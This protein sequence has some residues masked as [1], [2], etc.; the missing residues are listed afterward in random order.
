MDKLKQLYD[1][2]YASGD[3]TKSFED[4]KTQFSTLE[5]ISNL[6]NGLVESGDYTKSIGEFNVQF[7]AH[8]KKKDKTQISP[9]V[10][11]D[12]TSVSPSGKVDKKTDESFDSISQFV[13]PEEPLSYNVPEAEPVVKLSKDE[14][15]ANISNG[16]GS[17]DLND[18]I[19]N[20]QGERI[21]FFD[22]Y[23]K[24]EDEL[25]KLKLE[26]IRIDNLPKYN[27]GITSKS[28]LY[29]D[30]ITAN[31][32]NIENASK[33]WTEYVQQK[34][35]ANGGNVNFLSKV[36]LAQS[37]VN[38]DYIKTDAFI[39]NGE[40]TSYNDM[41]SKLMSGDFMDD[42]KS[43][44]INISINGD[45]NSVKNGIT[46]K[47]N[48]DELIKLFN[49]QKNSV[50]K[51][52]GLVDIFAGAILSTIGGRLKA[53]EFLTNI[54]ISGLTGAKVSDVKNFRDA[55]PSIGGIST[56]L[57]PAINAI[58]KGV[59]FLDNRQFKEDKSLINAIDDGDFLHVGMLVAEKTVGM[60]P[61]VIEGALTGGAAPYL[62]ALGAVG[63]K[64]EALVDENEMAIIRKENGLNLSKDEWNA[65]N[66]SNSQMILNAGF[67]G[68]L[69]G[70]LFGKWAE[71][72]HI[73][74][75]FM[76]FNPKKV[77]D[78][79]KSFSDGILNG[80]KSLG[81][82]FSNQGKGFVANVLNQEKLLLGLTGGNY[83]VDAATGI[84]KTKTIG[85]DLAERAVEGV[86]LAIP[87][88]GLEIKNE[89]KQIKTIRDHTTKLLLLDKLDRMMYDDVA[90]MS[91]FAEME[92]S[93][94][95]QDLARDLIK[96]NYAEM[97]I[98][99][100]K[101]KEH[102]ALMSSKEK[103]K[104]IQDHQDIVDLG[105][106]LE[107][108]GEGSKEGKVLSKLID[109]KVKEFE[110]NREKLIEKYQPEVDIIESEK[111]GLTPNT[112]DSR[113]T[114]ET[115]SSETME[116][117]MIST[118]PDGQPANT[119]KEGDV[120]RITVNKLGTDGY[121]R[122]N[123]QMTQSF[124]T[125]E[126]ARNYANKFISKDTKKEVKKGAITPE[127]SINYSNLTED[128][129]GNFVF[130][131]RT[132]T[133]I[134]S[135]DPKKSGSNK[136]APTSKEEVV[137]NNK[138][139]G[140]SF[141][142]TSSKSGESTVTGKNTYEVKIPKD[143]VY[144][145]DA[146][147]LNLKD[148]AKELH[149][150]EFPN[151]AFDSNTKLAYITKLAGEKGFD[152][153]VAK[154]N[155]ETRAQS[156]KVIK[157]TDVQVSGTKKVFKDNH[158]PNTEKGFETVESVSKD[159]ELEKVYSKII[160][161]IS[162]DAKNPLY[163]LKDQSFYGFKDDFS[164]FKTQESITKVIEESKLPKKLKDEYKK[165]L[166]TVDVKGY[167]KQTGK[168][169]AD[170]FTGKAKEASSKV[171]YKPVLNVDQ[172]TKVAKSFLKFTDGG[173]FTGHISKMIAGFAEKQLKVAE[174]IVSGKFK[175]F[176]DLGSSE[177]GL[178]KTVGE[179]SP[180]MKVVGIDPNPTMRKNFNKTPKVKN[181]DYRLE[182]LGASW[183]EADG[184]VIKEFKPKEKFDVINED[185]TF[186]F[187]NGDRKTQIK[188]VKEILTEDGLFITSEKMHTANSKKNEAKKYDHQKKYFNK[189]QL[190]ED[191]QTIISGMDKDMI[192]DVEYFKILSDNFKY[193]KEF[194]NAGDFKG[195]IAS[196][197]LSKVERFLKDVG[198][199]DSEFTDRESLTRDIKK[200][201][202]VEKKTNLDLNN[203]F[204]ELGF[205][206]SNKE[207]HFGK[208]ELQKD[209][210]YLKDKDRMLEISDILSNNEKLDA[211][212]EKVKSEDEILKEKLNKEVE[213]LKKDAKTVLDGIKIGKM[214][215]DNIKKRAI[216]IA[217]KFIAREDLQKMTGIEFK[218]ILTKIERAKTE[219]TIQNLVKKI[220][221]QIHLTEYRVNEAKVNKLLKAKF[222]KIESGRL[223]ANTATEEVA[224]MM[225]TIKVNIDTKG[226]KKENLYSD[227][228]A[229][230]LEKIDALNKK[231]QLTIKE[232]LDLEALSISNDILN[233]KLLGND[234][235]E[236]KANFLRDSFNRLKELRDAD[237]VKL[238]EIVDAQKKLDKEFIE[239]GIED[240]D[241]TGKRES[242]KNKIKNSEDL[243]KQANQAKHILTRTAFNLL[244]GNASGTLESII[245]IISR[246]GGDT[247]G[248]S[249]LGRMKAGLVHDIMQRGKYIDV[250]AKRIS[251]MTKSIFGRSDRFSRAISVDPKSI[252]GLGNRIDITIR[253]KGKDGEIIEGVVKFSENEL[254]DVWLMGKMELNLNG[255]ETSGFDAKALKDVDSK[256][257]NKSKEYGLEILD[258]YKDIYKDVNDTYK[259]MFNHSLPYAD[260]YSGMVRRINNKY[261]ET[262]LFNRGRFV[263]DK[264]NST[265]IKK[266][267]NSEIIIEGAVEKLNRYLNDASHYIHL[268]ESQR[269]FE[270]LIK[271]E[272]FKKAVM[273]ANGVVGADMINM[274]NF[275]NDNI[276][277]RNK[278]SSH[279]IIDFF[280]RNAVT[281]TLS[282]KGKIGL[283][284]T[285]S[286][287]NGLIEM[288]K[289][290]KIGEIASTIPHLIKDLKHIYESSGLL[291]QRYK[292]VGFEDAQTAL[293]EV[294]KPSKSESAQ[295]EIVKQY[296]YNSFNAMKAIGMSPV[297]IG[298]FIGVSGS[299]PLYR[300]WKAK[301]I[302]DKIPEPQA[303]KMAI[304][305]F[306]N[307]VD[308]Q[309]QANSPL[310]KTPLQHHQFGR[311]LASLASA[312]TQQ[313]QNAA[314]HFREMKRELFKE[315]HKGTFGRNLLG[316]I[317][318]RF[319]QPLAY[320]W[321]SNA[322]TGSAITAGVN[323]INGNGKESTEADKDILAALIAG[324]PDSVI[325]AGN[326]LKYLIDTVLVGK[327]RSYGG[328]YNHFIEDNILDLE[329]FLKLTVESKNPDTRL[330][331]AEKAIALFSKLL[332]AVPSKA[333]DLYIYWE[334]LQSDK[335]TDYERNLIIY[336][337]WSVTAIKNSRPLNPKR[338]FL[339]T[340][341][342]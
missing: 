310:H 201:I 157:P 317:N 315:G 270:M 21:K 160:E 255:L 219:R 186:Q 300:I 208:R 17:E 50:D 22:K 273:S 57:R 254:L 290:V 202:T 67:T 51:V 99:L 128:A 299:I 108:V 83:I 84:N 55:V 209:E 227:R 319:A 24:S 30:A 122:T 20:P 161:S 61:F 261:E 79:N 260:F 1:G 37:G 203:E 314:F 44:K 116:V 174:A 297:L 200:D 107:K 117:T 241:P 306:E 47:E 66:Y 286:I 82:A 29:Q 92:L 195:F 127:E 33:G 16:K 45:S 244:S 265:K 172:T 235:G 334:D 196:N 125:V 14:F 187:I 199:L 124:E 217:K 336:G 329:K 63:D 282:L 214:S 301:F 70:V 113:G 279:N 43:G 159:K 184:T 304:S 236:M 106:D 175:K 264:W 307:A 302:K 190:T 135:I 337:G 169:N 97:R 287:I 204:N 28:H 323:L 19:E 143:K 232:R 120:F 182:A 316:F 146:D 247:R 292:L 339:G 56:S 259:R 324:N 281:A 293:Q 210:Q 93:G 283:A 218:G 253:K 274:L 152:M 332:I 342:N 215:R 115:Y 193:V 177:G 95:A 233:A 109:G 229:L 145:F 248:D 291:Q 226:S 80:G 330:K 78:F 104:L 26:D 262:D 90:N 112:P 308:R 335:F 15:I 38:F 81:D 267:G 294:A 111:V 88:R 86:G 41:A 147:P 245:N 49:R 138:V 181:V 305:K 118:R 192:N 289:G 341:V 6:H 105:K 318:Y 3:Y 77:V 154:W 322:F 46:D 239:A 197:S 132:E 327:E 311:Y 251:D 338:K 2:L 225:K 234:Y 4:F 256:L 155:G 213:T 252:A 103:N 150:K 228:I 72:M 185:F 280:A 220:V 170:F 242:N 258:I 42:V 328:L 140:L 36:D 18:I 35:E 206:T 180:K 246:Q 98:N 89:S 272:G 285:A 5:S 277:K 129:S 221:N 257:S 326:V 64:G 40:N 163:E 133:D 313:H 296:V 151:Q 278:I 205:S 268:S 73:S 94:T 114:A 156:T 162:G 85:R 171:P 240:A 7:F 230:N 91:D 59:E 100:D 275:Y 183:V 249:H 263:N 331:N 71:S 27:T 11:L 75:K 87:F 222:T 303:E 74:G 198:D 271:N 223:K 10:S 312:P 231:E 325:V 131:H 48:T 121:M 102:V 130:Y 34:I 101:S 25:S 53:L 284:Q 178:I 166:E 295:A 119:K 68:L 167:S 62:F 60:I 164:P 266:G 250:Y 158:V 8:V 237:R 298:D 216:D 194:W 69:T 288:P 52:A 212:K 142:Y 269:Q 76:K 188:Q 243:R 31:N 65:Y 110:T 137:A 9:S 149:A 207:K 238:Q 141:F 136:K 224:D 173:N 179:N 168:Q 321:V 165:A 126:E 12:T 320:A 54:A 139:G 189:E 148:A 39:I 23:V 191:K 96:K 176:L 211:K 309:Q 276:L 134:T 123:N 13:T 340:S 144:D 58:D 153:V 32:I 333:T